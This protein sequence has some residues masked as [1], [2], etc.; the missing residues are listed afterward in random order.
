MFVCGYFCLYLE[1]SPHYSPGFASGIAVRIS[2]LLVQVKEKIVPQSPHEWTQI[3]S[4][5]RPEVWWYHFIYFT[6]FF[7]TFYVYHITIILNPE[8]ARNWIFCRNS[9]ILDRPDETSQFLS[10]ASSSP[11]ADRS[12]CHRGFDSM[13]CFNCITLLLTYSVGVGLD[14][15]LQPLHCSSYLLFQGQHVVLLLASFQGH[16]LKVC[17]LMA[18]TVDTSNKSRRVTQS[19]WLTTLLKGLKHMLMG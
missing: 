11:R 18:Q 15:A 17:G 2:P 14:V 9:Q 10:A 4:S 1:S 7:R 16:W 6:R 12:S 13:S 19:M 3:H 5:L 8:S